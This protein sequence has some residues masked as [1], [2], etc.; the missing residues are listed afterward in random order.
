MLCEMGLR[1][2]P[3]YCFVIGVNFLT[4]LC[5]QNNINWNI[6]IE[7]GKLVIGFKLIDGGFQN[8]DDGQDRVDSFRPIQQHEEEASSVLEDMEVGQRPAVVAP[9]NSEVEKVI[10]ELEEWKNKQKEQFKQQVLI[11]KICFPF[12]LS[13]FLTKLLQSC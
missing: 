5:R 2:E 13:A 7:I 6:F 11:Y 10:L 3:G 9:S 12:Q 8:A 1:N 4:K